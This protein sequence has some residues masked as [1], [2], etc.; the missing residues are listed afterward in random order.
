L[1]RADIGTHANHQN[2]NPFDVIR[3]PIVVGDKI[4]VAR[5]VRGAGLL[6]WT[7]AGGGLVGSGVV[8]VILA[9]VGQYDDHLGSCARA[10]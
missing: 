7:A 9:T 6:G 5:S 3:D 10:G 8:N 2:L 1:R 4:I